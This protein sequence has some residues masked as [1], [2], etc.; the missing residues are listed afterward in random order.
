MFTDPITIWLPVIGTGKYPDMYRPAGLR[1]REAIDSE[2]RGDA[3]PVPHIK[4]THIIP[5]LGDTSLPVRPQPDGS[6]RTNEQ[7]S[8]PH[9]GDPAVDWAETVIESEDLATVDA[10]LVERG[11]AR[12]AVGDVPFE[13][14]LMRD[15]DQARTTSGIAMTEE[16]E[17]RCREILQSAVD[18]KDTADGRKTLTRLIAHMSYKGMDPEETA[19]LAGEYN[20]DD[21]VDYSRGI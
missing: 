1:I 15:L 10:S 17:Q 9:R 19:R 7:D 4:S 2:Y 21:E 3:E 8:S 5:S 13:D 12:R 14:R 18:L 20:A 6:F 11:L 16:E